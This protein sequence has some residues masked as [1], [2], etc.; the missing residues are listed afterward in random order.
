MY[1]ISTVLKDIIPT[2]Q[3]STPIE[4]VSRFKLSFGSERTQAAQAMQAHSRHEHNAGPLL[5][6]LPNKYEVLESAA[7]S[8]HAWICDI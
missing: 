1:S 6:L 7:V 8:R 4:R 3:D 5:E 2:C